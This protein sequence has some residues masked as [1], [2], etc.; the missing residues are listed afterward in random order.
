M[1][2]T[3]W[4]TV[5]NCYLLWRLNPTAFS[6]AIWASTRRS[7][8]RLMG[9]FRTGNVDTQRGGR[10]VNVLSNSRNSSMRSGGVSGVRRVKTRSRVIIRPQTTSSKSSVRVPRESW[11]TRL[12]NRSAYLRWTAWVA[13]N[14]YDERTP[15][16]VRAP[17]RAVKAQRLFRL[18]RLRPKNRP[19]SNPTA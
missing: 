15:V 1:V 8:L 2:R 4:L 11:R 10:T 18:S 14:L 19:T 3:F 17:K 6:V 13:T 16:R 12:R 9:L 7:C 5:V